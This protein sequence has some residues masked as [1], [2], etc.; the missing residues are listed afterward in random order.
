MPLEGRREGSVGE[1]LAA[2]A[3]VMEALKT[4]CREDPRRLLVN[5]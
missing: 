5:Q 2:I 1:M 4:Q 3:H